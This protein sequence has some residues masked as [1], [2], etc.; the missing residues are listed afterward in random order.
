MMDDEN[1]YIS[2][3]I[4]RDIFYDEKNN[5]NNNKLGVPG[6]ASTVNPGYVGVG[7]SPPG[8][9]SFSKID[10]RRFNITVQDRNLIGVQSNINNL[11]A[12]I[13]NLETDRISKPCILPSAPP[14][15][16]QSTIN[17]YFTSEMQQQPLN[18]AREQPDISN[19]V[20]LT[21]SATIMKQR[22]PFGSAKNF[23]TFTDDSNNNRNFDTSSRAINNGNI[24]DSQYLYREHPTDSSHFLVTL[25]ILIHIQNYIFI[26]NFSIL[27]N[28]YQK[29]RTTVH[30]IL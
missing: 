16:R 25:I 18:A 3:D 27:H 15:R 12:R 9:N 26:K 8:S 23:P 10:H 14:L 6:T 20:S 1:R 5:N 22:H 24:R 11:N 30:L 2:E 13:N 7:R 28:N 17:N 4:Q 21:S 19:L 29:F